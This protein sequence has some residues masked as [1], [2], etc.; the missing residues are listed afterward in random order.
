[1]LFAHGAETALGGS[2]EFLEGATGHRLATLI[3]H[4]FLEDLAAEC[5][6][7]GFI[8]RSGGGD[9]GTKLGKKVVCGYEFGR[10]E[11]S[12]WHARLLAVER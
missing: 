3:V 10:G 9:S 5:P 1:M 11:A 8:A 7:K 4:E 2:L 12:M 6:Y